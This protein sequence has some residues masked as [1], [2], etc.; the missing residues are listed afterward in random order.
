MMNEI[1]NDSE[2][3]TVSLHLSKQ[4][5]IELQKRIAALKDSIAVLFEDTYACKHILLK[6]STAVLYAASFFRNSLYRR[7]KV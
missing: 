7:V 3:E 6:S 5:E 4:K 1:L 2:F